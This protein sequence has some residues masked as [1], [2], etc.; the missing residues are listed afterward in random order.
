MGDLRAAWRRDTDVRAAWTAVFEDIGLNP[1]DTCYDW[2]YIRALPP[3]K[4]HLGRDTPRLPPHRDTWGS[5]IYQQI[6]WWAPVF[7]I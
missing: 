5:N 1:A 6:N 7:P 4:T 2:F 3:G